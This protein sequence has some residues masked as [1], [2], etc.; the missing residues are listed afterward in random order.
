M[1]VQN[2]IIPGFHPDPSICRVDDD[3][4]LVTSSFEYVPGVPV[5]HSR[6]LVHWQCLGYCLTRPEQLPLP[7]SEPSLGIFAPTI[8]FHQGNFY[9]VTTNMDLQA[10][11]GGRSN[12]YVTARD[13]RGPWSDPIWLEQGGIDP[14]L[15][16]D[17]DGRVYLTSTAEGQEQGIQQSEIDPVTGRLL[18]KPRLLWRGTGGAYPEGP[19]LYKID[20][21]Y[22]LMI[23]EGGTSYGHME[24]LVRGPTPWGPWEA[25]PHNPIL[26]HRSLL[27][28]IQATGHAD[29]VQAQDG[30]W[31]LVCLGI[32]PQPFTGLHQ[33]GRETFL[34]PVVWD[35]RGW[36]HVGE[37]GRLKQT[38]EGP[39][40]PSVSWPAR[41]VR[42]D[43]DQPTLGL[44]W[45]FLRWPPPGSWSLAARPGFL[46]LLGN[47]A[48]L[49]Q[50]HAVAFVGR[51]QEHGQCTVTAQL[52]FASQIEGHE[53]G[54]TVWMNREHHYEIAVLCQE[55]E[56]WVI[57]R[58]RIGSLAAIVA[59]ERVEAGPITLGIR[60]IQPTQPAFGAVSLY[61]FSYTQGEAGRRELAQGEARYLT[62]EVAGG[63]TG[64]YFALYATTNGRS[65]TAVADF[66]WV[67]Y[68][69][70]PDFAS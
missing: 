58:R 5:F 8:R 28:P 52:E 24:T 66:D 49:D 36:P 27:S 14:S 17:D 63:F 45:N 15:F 59:R 26:S 32:R 9:M 42:D 12:F 53:A 13:P 16:F 18:T 11:R 30:S 35:S 48:T 47:T 55:G 7:R 2:P 64:V 39:Q 3:Y 4:Y 37:N 29:L 69:P 62:S 25:C 6:D 19:H 33:L 56:H 22:Y 61:L 54:L 65:G 51:R 50:G 10:E 44:D 70:A 57:V 34:A 31:W 46:R 68:Q 60:A 20:G 40:L 43:F 23:A 41:A 1:Q 21:R 38:F 67:E